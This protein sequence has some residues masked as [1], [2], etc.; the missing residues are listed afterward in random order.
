MLTSIISFL[1]EKFGAAIL[2]KISAVLFGLL[3]GLLLW[4]YFSNTHLENENKDLNTKITN[5]TAERDQAKSDLSKYKDEVS[6][7]AAIDASV[8]PAQ[9]AIQ[10]Q[11]VEVIH[12]V[13]KYRD[14]PAVVHTTLSPQWV[15]THDTAASTV[16]AVNLV[17]GSASSQPTTAQVSCTST[18]GVSDSDALEVVTA[19]YATYIDLQL[20]YNRLWAECSGYDPRHR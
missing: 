1:T 14:N 7:K 16:P 11:K 3:G 6:R 12:E 19:N 8:Q 9:Q 10:I 18:T 5:V 17:G 4:F 13:I 15:C 20:N 2:P